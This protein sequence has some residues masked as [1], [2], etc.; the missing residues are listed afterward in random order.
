MNGFPGLL[1]AFTLEVV[2][3]AV[4]SLDCA[5]N[6]RPTTIAGQRLRTLQRFGFRGVEKCR[7]RGALYAG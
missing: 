3:A 7:R 5:G 1:I 2:V 6:F 4:G